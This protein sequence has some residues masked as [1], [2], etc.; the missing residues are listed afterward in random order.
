MRP[1]PVP[2]WERSGP[3]PD[4]RRAVDRP[5]R[6]Y[7]EHARE[8]EAHLLS[9]RDYVRWGASRFV[10][11]G[12]C[13]G[14]GHADALDESAA[15]VLH[16]LHLESGPPPE[17]WAARLTPRERGVVLSLFHRRIRDRVPAAYLTGHAWFAGLRLRADPRALVPRS[18]LAEWIE[19]GFAP[20]REPDAIHRV[21][22]IGTGG[23]CIAIA[24]AAFFPA[25]R[26]D[27]VDIDHDALALAGANLRDHGLEERV[28][29]IE[30]DLF[31]GVEGTYDLIIANPP[32]VGQGEYE[33]LP[34]EYRHEPAR[35][36]R[37]DDDGVAIIA[38]ILR[39]A[40]P[41][42]EREGLLVVEA[43]SCRPALERRFSGLPF[44]WLELRR[45]GE[46]V[47]LLRRD[48]LPR[49]PGDPGRA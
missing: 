31:A 15:L 44:T 9:M 19:R 42:L 11:A 2:H 35:G 6:S 37:A 21:L 38:R 24:C 27:A 45:G 12:L 18:P 14:H 36:L 39:N 1:G 33:S 4:P 29:L 43:G 28:R 49:G 17:L 20:W 26:I 47:F 22:D 13:F 16:A 40:A 5:I 41:H 30:S 23:G 46:N 7:L 8:A 34:A 25:A 10:E 32:Y 3:A 48:E